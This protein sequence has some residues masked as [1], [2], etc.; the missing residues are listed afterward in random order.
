MSSFTPKYNNLNLGYS[1][2]LQQVLAIS[3]HWE[4]LVDVAKTEKYI[5]GLDLHL[6]VLIVLVSFLFLFFIF[7][8]FSY[9]QIKKGKIFVVAFT[10]YCFW[11][12]CH[13]RVLWVQ[14][15]YFSY[16]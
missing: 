4:S 5:Q 10:I 6:L 9:C 11:I 7:L 16:V 1:Y 3:E 14:V 15:W 13:P 8:H 12:L 2:I